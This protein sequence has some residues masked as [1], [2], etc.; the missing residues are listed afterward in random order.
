MYDA[1]DPR[2]GLAQATPSKPAAGPG[3]P[4]TYAR[5]Y[6]QAPQ[7]NDRTE[8][9][10]IVRG[11]TFVLV[12]TQIVAETVFERGNQPDEYALLI[13]DQA[14]PAI[15]EAGGETQTIDGYSL[16]FIPPGDSSIRLPKGGRVV[17]LFTNAA[18][19]LLEQASNAA[20]YAEPNP[21][22]PALAAW[23]APPDGYRIRSYSLDVPPQPGRFGR[24]FRGST[25]MVNFLEPK[26]G[27]RDPSLLSP[28]DHD[29]F[30]QCSLAL[31]GEYIH[32]LRWPWT[33]D[34][35]H[36]REDDHETCA[37]PSV[38]VIPPRVI[39]TSQAIGAGINQ[40]VDIFCPPRADFSAKPG[41]V[42]NADDYPLPVRS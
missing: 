8:Q 3:F 42:L 23:P 19:D 35:A 21:D 41:W 27:P 1:S 15:V 24:I 10:W 40:L 25:F 32:H 16:T 31:S 34:R 11:Q 29:D 9:A 13:P 38:A 39:H 30:E 20:L 18:T 14:T 4:A 26:H 33:T 2:A 28:H 37:S 36:W 6:E 5:F 22:V 17:R 7:Q 12:Y